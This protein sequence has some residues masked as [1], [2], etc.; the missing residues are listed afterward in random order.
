[1]PALSSYER[2][3]RLALPFLP[4][5]YRTVRR[6]VRDLLADVA[7]ER[8]LVLDAG[9]RKS[10]YTVGL[11]VG[12]IIADL[13]RASE[14]QRGLNLGVLADGVAHLRQRRSNVDAF[15]FGDVT[16]SSFRAGSF[17]GVLAVEVLEHVEADDQFVGEV[18]RVLR[19][20]G[21]F[22]MTTPNGDFNPIPNPA[23]VRH[24]PR[25]DLLRLLHRH[26]GI[27]SVRYAI[28]TGRWRRYGLESWSPRRPLVTLRSAVANVIN[29]VQ[30]RSSGAA[31]RQDG[32]ASLIA[33]C[34]DP[35]PPP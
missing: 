27:V 19:D 21:W 32:T 9:G 10:Q 1:M 23:H 28:S 30:S 5:L 14:F 29:A 12:V 34:R 35:K 6:A 16:F 25:D 3:Y 11:P 31:Q 13:P 22:V 17:D 33:V 2:G 8:P 26:F 20:D 4:P 7:S 18:A 15:V 24:Y